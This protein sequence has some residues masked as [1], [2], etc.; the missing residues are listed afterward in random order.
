VVDASKTGDTGKHLQRQQLEVFQS[1]VA[2]GAM[3]MVKSQTSSAWSHHGNRNTTGA[4]TT[5]S[6]DLSYYLVFT[7]V[8]KQTC[9]L[10][11]RL[12]SRLKVSLILLKRNAHARL[13][14]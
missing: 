11:I 12:G 14:K 2:G 5:V 3:H 9:H 7:Y 1:K 8:G 6:F 10:S 4:S 13:S